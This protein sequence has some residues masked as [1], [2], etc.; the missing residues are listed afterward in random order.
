M[1]QDFLKPPTCLRRLAYIC[2]AK[3]PLACVPGIPVAIHCPQIG[4]AL[5]LGWNHGLRQRCPGVSGTIYFHAN[6]KSIALSHRLKAALNWWLRFLWSAPTKLLPLQLRLRVALT[7]YADATGDGTL[8]WVA[9]C[10][11]Y[12]EWSSVP[13]LRRWTM[14]SY[15]P[16]GVPWCS[17]SHWAASQRLV[18]A[19][20]AL[21]LRWLADSR[22][23]VAAGGAAPHYRLGAGKAS[24]LRPNACRLPPNA[25]DA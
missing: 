8:A 7:L 6:G 13:S 19:R 22:G 20:K 2:L 21:C 25:A 16:G 12:R 10:V 1:W 5:K 15:A 24:E 4:W 18:R 11:D 3:R 14:S 17:L 9:C 23:A